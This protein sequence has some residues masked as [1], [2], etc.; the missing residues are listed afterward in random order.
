MSEHV[1]DIQGIS[2]VSYL[3]TR[4]RL[5][6]K[7]N[8]TGTMRAVLERLRQSGLLREQDEGGGAPHTNLREQ[9]SHILSGE[10]HLP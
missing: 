10:L 3:L 5:A 7:Q 8:E 2:D 1:E 9:V 6:K 4:L